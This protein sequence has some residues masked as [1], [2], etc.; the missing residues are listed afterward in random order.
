MVSCSQMGNYRART[1]RTAR[2]FLW[3][4]RVNLYNAVVSTVMKNEK[5]R[6]IEAKLLVPH[7]MLLYLNRW[8][9]ICINNNIPQFLSGF[10][11]EIYWKRA[12]WPKNDILSILYFAKITCSKFNRGHCST[13]NEHICHYYYARHD[14]AVKIFLSRDRLVNKIFWTERSQSSNVQAA[15]IA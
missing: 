11:N 6:H 14:G 10:E 8:R 12:E 4:N 2:T 3:E 5:R 7:F 13:L 1:A 9:R 15:L